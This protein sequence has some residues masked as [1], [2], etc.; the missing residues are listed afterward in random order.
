LSI[1]FVTKSRKKIY[2]FQKTSFLNICLALSIVAI[3]FLTLVAPILPQTSA[4]NR[5]GI[6]NFSSPSKLI[7]VTRNSGT[8]TA[9]I[10][11]QKLLTG[12]L[13]QNRLEFLG[14]GP[15]RE[16]VLESNAY[17]FLSG[18]RD[19]RSPHSWFYGNFGRFG[20]LGLILWHLICI[21]FIRAQKSRLQVFDLPANI[22]IVIYLIA[23]FGVVMES[24]FGILPFSFFL[25][26][27]KLRD[28]S[29]ND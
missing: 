2:S 16:M 23:L 8:A 17:M 18:K 27:G 15:G 28:L 5:I 4:L 10:E 29:K 3:P 25:G 24:P 7:Q 12:W 14:A 13:Y 9:R 22:L 19:V 1:Y 6:E 21:L 11:A 20:Y 26:G